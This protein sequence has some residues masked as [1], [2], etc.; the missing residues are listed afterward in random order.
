MPDRLAGRRLQRTCAAKCRQRSFAF[1]AFGI[2][3]GHSNQ[4]CSGLRADAESFAKS[5]GML[6]G[7][8][9]KYGVECFELL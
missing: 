2:V 1:Q 7:Q 9:V 8:A 6:A 3:T 5:P 4:Y